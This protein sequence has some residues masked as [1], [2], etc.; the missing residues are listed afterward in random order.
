MKSRTNVIKM[1]LTLSLG[2]LVVH[3]YYEFSLSERIWTFVLHQTHDHNPGLASDIELIAVALLGFG[4]AW[5]VVTKLV[6]ILLSQK[7]N[8]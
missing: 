7:P 2:W 5:F 3:F 8:D 1:V 6:N 4:F